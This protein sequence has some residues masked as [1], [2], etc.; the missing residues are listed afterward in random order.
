MAKFL[1]TGGA[2][3]IGSHLVR[4]LI[5]RGNA[6]RV[7]DDFSTGKRENLHD[8]APLIEIHEG[9]IEDRA[10]VARAMQGVDYCL[11]QAAIPSVPRSVADPWA[12]N[13]ANVEG[14]LNVFV[15]AKDAG[16][17]R[18]V[19]AS[20]SS[21][22]GNVERMPVSESLPRA[23]ISPY[24][25][26]KAAD[27]LYGEVFSGL[28]GLDVVAL[29]YFNV[30]GPRQDPDSP[31]AAVVPIFLE[32]MLRGERPPVHGHGQQARDFTYVENVVQANLRACQ[33]EGRLSGAYNIACGAS[34]SIVELVGMMNALL[35]TS[36]PP[37][38]LPARAG[39]ILRSW[40]DISRA[41]RAFGYS[42]LVTLKEGLEKTITWFK[43]KGAQP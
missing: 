22:Y 33:A 32:K 21:I 39:D 29:R 20:S 40:A 10:L 41:Q 17:K 16:V 38:H 15:A 18:V 2:G 34:T 5:A 31:Y 43:E 6:V 27:E 9:S 4:A 37:D 7:L 26:T 8:V 1:V 28:Y 19:F 12:S 23:P 3:F 36:L 14:T 35:G 13:R 30:F 24:G 25:V 42:P 11:H